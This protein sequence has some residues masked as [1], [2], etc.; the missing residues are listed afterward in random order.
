MPRSIR[1]VAFTTASVISLA[2][3]IATLGLWFHSTQRLDRLRS[4]TAIRRVTLH[5]KNGE[6]YID[7]STASAPIFRPGFEHIHALPTQ[8]RP[9][10][11]SWEFAGIG[12]G[13]QSFTNAQGTVVI[14]F[15]EIPLWPIAVISLV[16]PVL[17]FDARERKSAAQKPAAAPGTDPRPQPTA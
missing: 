6:I 11:A 2:V 14:R 15:V 5:S 7:V 12:A 4:G 9:P 1:R 17:W 3:C 16:L 8:Y 10:P 13:T